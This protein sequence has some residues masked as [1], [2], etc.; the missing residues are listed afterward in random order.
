MLRIQTSGSERKLYELQ[1]K[2]EALEKAAGKAQGT[3]PKTEKKIKDTGEA[4]KKTSKSINKLQNGLIKLGKTIAVG[5]AAMAWFRGFAAADQASGAVRTLGV[6]VDELKKKLFEVSVASGNLRSQTELLAASYDIASAGF[7]SAAEIST[8]LAASID[9]AVG[10]MTTMAKV[11][12]AATSVMNAYGM[13][14]DESRAL[15]DGFIQTQNDGKIVVDQYASQIGRL[16]PIAKAADIGISELNAAISS[17]T[18][19]GLP[20]EQTFTGMAMAIQGIMK[21]TGD[22]EKIARAFGF[23]F[24]AAALKAKGLGGVLMDMKTALHGNKEAMGRMFGSV[25]ALKAVLP[26][27]NDDLE[28]FNQNLENQKNSSG[29]AAKASLIMSGTVSQALGRIMD[30]IGNVVRNL[31]FLGVAFKAILSVVNDFISG[32]L[33][34][35]KWFQVVATSAVA[36]AVAVTALMPVLGGLMAGFV[37]LK[38]AAIAAGAALSIGLAPIFIGAGAVVAFTA[39]LAGLWAAFNKF[40]DLKNMTK[41]GFAESIIK[42]GDAEKVANELNKVEREI[43]KWEKRAQNEKE[44]KINFWVNANP[45]KLAKLKELQAELKAGLVELNKVSEDGVKIDEK[46]TKEQE[47]FLK[48]YRELFGPKDLEKQAGLKFIE[49]LEKEN[50]ML[51]ARLKGTEAL[52]KLEYEIAR[53]KLIAAGKSAEEAD[54]ILKNNE[55]LKK[56][57][58]KLK[59]IEELWKSIGD[60]IKEGVVDGIKSA[61]TGAKSFGEVMS[62]VLNRISDK[63]LNFAI[64]GMFSALGSQGGFWGKLFGGGKIGAGGLYADRPT[65][66]IIGHGKEYVLREDQLAGA[67]ARFAKGERGQSVIPMSSSSRQGELINDLGKSNDDKKLEISLAKYSGNSQMNEASN[68]IARSGGMRSNEPI[69]VSYNGPTLNFNGDEY[70][71]RASVPQI[72]DAAVKQGAK[73]GEARM[74]SSLKNSRSTRASLGL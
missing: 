15:I 57:V 30:G 22:A 47:E 34:L 10:G 4:A 32:F 58:S 69:N 59:Q 29:A 39:A 52:K 20:V 42:E 66:A 28:S 46:K 1:K 36:L 70:V 9:G 17:I 18:A 33:S 19:S 72:I 61:I 35:P 11:S 16:A 26:L 25:E 73:A 38:G 56:K 7:S 43:A 13:S 74:M 37:A 51:D 49:Q 27:L 48:K 68:S 63:L 40:K 6:N 12:D 45:E 23:E 21:P 65:Q 31:D 44:G 41:E 53:A 50:E 67:L 54:E 55:N 2:M 5:A 62:N 3:L 24:N 14:A 60:S 64:D 8:I 71:P